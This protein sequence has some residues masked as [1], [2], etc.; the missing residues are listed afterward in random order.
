[1]RRL[2]QPAALQRLWNAWNA[3]AVV[4]LPPDCPASISALQVSGLNTGAWGE[5][6]QRGSAPQQ[7]PCG[8]DAGGP[9]S[10][11]PPPLAAAAALTAP[12]LPAACL[13]ALPAL[14][15]CS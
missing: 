2:P 3:S 10:A 15:A 1:M 5:E 14:S 6:Q 11:A 4:A 8:D 7:Q 13:L 9:G 12:A